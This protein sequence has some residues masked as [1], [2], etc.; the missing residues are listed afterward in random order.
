MAMGVWTVGFLHWSCGSL[1]SFGVGPL[2]LLDFCGSV[3][4]CRRPGAAGF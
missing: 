1:C 3:Q 2:K 4:L